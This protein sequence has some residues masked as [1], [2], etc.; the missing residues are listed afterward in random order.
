MAKAP[1]C[2]EKGMLFNRVLSR[3]EEWLV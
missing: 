3:H 1:S 2:Q